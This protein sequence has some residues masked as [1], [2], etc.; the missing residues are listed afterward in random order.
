MAPNWFGHDRRSDRATLALL[1]ADTYAELP[2]HVKVVDVGAIDP[3]G[4]LIS[5]QGTGEFYLVTTYAEGVERARSATELDVGRAQ[6]L[7]GYLVELHKRPCRAPPELYVRAIRD[8]LGSGEGIFGI[9]DSYPLDRVIPLERLCA[10]E[11]RCVTWRWRLR[12][13]TGRLRRTHG[14]YHPYNVLFREGVDF[15]LL[16]ASRGGVGEPADDLAAMTINYVFGAA[17]HPTAWRTGLAPLWHAFWQTYL[18][19]SGDWEVLETIA[20]FFAWRGLV[21]ASPVWYPDIPPES[22]E[23]LLSFVESVLDAPVF[24][25][26]CLDRFIA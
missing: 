16:D 1:A 15:T 2:D 6:A 8:L 14:D 3:K 10:I 4:S 21:V 24:D 7:A 11:Q 25:P 23:T 13:R 9:A 20:P 26:S 12:G 22:R 18:H 5:L 19:A 17:V